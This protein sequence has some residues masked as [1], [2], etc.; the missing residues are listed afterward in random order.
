MTL[1]RRDFITLLGGTAAAW[2]LAARAQQPKVSVIGYLHSGLPGQDAENVAG[3]LK[4]MGETG[5]V[6]GRDVAI[7]HRWAENQYDRFPGLAADLVRRN[8]AVIFA[9]PPQMA[10]AAAKAATTT[11][12]IVFNN[13]SDPVSRGLVAS[14]NR[15]GGNVTGVV[16]NSGEIGSKRLGL[17]HEFVPTVATIA[18]LRNQNLD[19]APQIADLEAA[20]RRLG[21]KLLI[22]NAGTVSDLDQA[23]A[24]AA[25]Q[26]AGAA[27]AA[28]SAFFNQRRVQLAVLAAHYGIPTMGFSR[29][30]PAG[31]GLVS[32]GPSLPDSYRLAGLYVGRILKGEKPADLPVIQP[33]KFE[34]VI[35]LETAKT[36]CL[37]IPPGVLAIADEVIE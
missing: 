34:L 5:F 3:F 26:K 11:I 13:G 36:L 8:V 35:N 16:N 10:A 31:G 25:A 33:T 7:E 22:L 9:A 1:G 23:F 6:E 15:P 12:P 21:K 19:D 32:Y 18:V 4:G 20:A 2:P 27:V 29:E 28:T 14:F 24:A 37:T 17:L 30:F